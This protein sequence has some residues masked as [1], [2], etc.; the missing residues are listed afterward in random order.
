MELSI[1]ILGIGDSFKIL[2]VT[3]DLSLKERERERDVSNLNPPDLQSRGLSCSFK[4]HSCFW[5]DG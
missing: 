5:N 3:I 1:F 2:K 4:G